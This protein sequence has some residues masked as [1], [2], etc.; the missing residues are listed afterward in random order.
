MSSYKKNVE[1]AVT[2]ALVGVG[3]GV[4]VHLGR[5]PKLKKKVKRN[6][7]AAYDGVME[8]V[9]KY[10][11]DVQNM[12]SKEEEKNEFVNE[13]FHPENCC[14]AAGLHLLADWVDSGGTLAPLTALRI[15]QHFSK[16]CGSANHVEPGDDPCHFGPDEAVV[17]THLL[18]VAT[19]KE[20]KTW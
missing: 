8:M 20:P 4:L 7:Y 19:G 17:V 12:L 6:L 3:I 18:N 14:H 11:T 1:A 5:D 2:A 9:A 16:A 13:F 10:T 15:K